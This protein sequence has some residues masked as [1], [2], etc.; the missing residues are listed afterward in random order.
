MTRPVEYRQF[1]VLTA[2]Q[3]QKMSAPFIRLGY[4]H[5]ENTQAYWALI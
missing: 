1:V 3:G 5:I 4:G 2:H